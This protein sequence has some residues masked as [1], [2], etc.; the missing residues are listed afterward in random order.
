MN[1]KFFKSDELEK[2]IRLSV[3]K[4]GKLGFTMEAAKSL[5]LTPEKSFLIGRNEDDPND[6][7]LYLVL[8][9]GVTPGS[10]KVAKA[11]DYYYL[12]IKLL[13]DNLEVPYEKENVAYNMEKIE[14]GEAIY[15][16]LSRIE[17]KKKKK[18][19]ENGT[20]EEFA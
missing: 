20:E 3:H 19:D 1:I 15:Y 6:D 7:R 18:R 4:S 9:Q 2:P 5:E 12:P 10:F 14:D 11:G 17:N 16:R 13:L 8:N